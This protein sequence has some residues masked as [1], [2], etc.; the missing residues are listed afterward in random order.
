M[1]ERTFDKALVHGPQLVQA[2]NE[3][4]AAPKHRRLR[5]VE[6]RDADENLSAF[7]NLVRLARQTDTRNQH[8]VAL[9]TRQQAA[10]RTNDMLSVD[11]SSPSASS[12]SLPSSDLLS[13]SST[14]AESW[15]SSRRRASSCT[16][17]TIS[18]HIMFAS[19]T[20]MMV[21]TSWSSSIDRN[22]DARSCLA[23]KAAAT[24]SCCFNLAFISSRVCRSFSSN[25]FFSCIRRSSFSFLDASLMA[26]F[27]FSSSAACL[28]NSS[29]SA[30]CWAS[31]IWRCM[32]FS[33]MGGKEQ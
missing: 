29:A 33:C 32:V 10:P 5:L 12:S 25:S 20:F 7:P 8:A 11:S 26:A 9:N 16:P 19:L 18:L 14:S 21:S 15:R 4:F 6:M 30:C 31:W 23:C 3:C 17:V 1:H 2:R 28:A 13:S 22:R 27:R 24:S